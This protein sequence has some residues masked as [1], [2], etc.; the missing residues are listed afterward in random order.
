METCAPH[1]D[2]V[3]T[4]RSFCDD[5]PLIVSAVT[6]LP[7]WNPY[8]VGPRREPGPGELPP[9]V[10][11]RQASQLAAAWTL[12]SI[13]YLAEAG[14]ASATYYETAGWRGVM[15]RED[16]SPDPELFPSEPGQPFP[17]LSRI[18]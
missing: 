4:A 6:L 15:E 7:R 10:D 16:G 2:T 1:A 17:A 9:E 14:V 13:K 3:R 11:P 5:L 8:L 12:G 18:R